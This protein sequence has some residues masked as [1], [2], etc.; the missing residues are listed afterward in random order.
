MG[1]LQRF[2]GIERKPGEPEPVDDGLFDE[3]LSGDGRPVF[4]FF[5]SLWCPQ[6]QVMHGLLNELG[7]LFAGRAR[8]LRMDVSKNP[9][10]PGRFDIRGIPQIIVFHGGTPAGRLS[11]L[12]PI[13]ELR[14]W[15]EAR[16]SGAAGAGGEKGNS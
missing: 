1:F 15:I 9:R 12:I 4:V 8:F 10:T 6:C 2:L 5:Y 16:M 7:P 14:E 13:D 3:A 11:G